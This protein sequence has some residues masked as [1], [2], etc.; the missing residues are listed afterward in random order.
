MSMKVE[1]HWVEGG[2]LFATVSSDNRE[3]LVEGIR[4]FVMEQIEQGKILRED[5][6]PDDLRNWV[7]AGVEKVESPFA[8]DPKQPD[9][10]A[11]KLA[12]ANPGKKFNWMY[13]QTV[14]LTRPL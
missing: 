13:K 6:K 5:K 14:R 4:H 9:E 2:Q 1:R 11:H 3:E 12:T 7:G 10:D 8:Y